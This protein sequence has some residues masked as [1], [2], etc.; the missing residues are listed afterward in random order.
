MDKQSKLIFERYSRRTILEQT[1]VNNIA[2]VSIGTPMRT[3]PQAGQQ[4]QS[5]IKQGASQAIIGLGRFFAEN[6]F[7]ALL[8]T[9]DLTP[10]TNIVQI[11]YLVDVYDKQPNIMN[12]T[13]L[14]LGG[15]SVLPYA[16]Q[17][18][19]WFARATK[20]ASNPTVRQLSQ[21][22]PFRDK[23]FNSN[24]VKQVINT[25]RQAVFNNQLMETIINTLPANTR[26]TFIKAR[27]QMVKELNSPEVL[28]VLNATNKE[29]QDA[30]YY[31]S[32]YG[33]ITKPNVFGGT[34]TKGSQLRN[35]KRLGKVPSGENMIKLEQLIRGLQNVQKVVINMDQLPTSIVNT[36][37]R[38]TSQIKEIID[39]LPTVPS[40]KMASS[41]LFTNIE[42]LTKVLL[43]TFNQTD[44]LKNLPDDQ[45]ISFLE[46]IKGPLSKIDET[47]VITIDKLKDII[48]N[49]GKQTDEFLLAMDELVS[50]LV[51]TYN[52]KLSKFDDEIA[53]FGKEKLSINI[54]RFSNYALPSSRALEDKSKKKTSLVGKV[55]LGVGKF[56]V[57]STIGFI[58]VFI[59]ALYVLG[60]LGEFVNYIKSFVPSSESE[61]YPNEPEE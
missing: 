50:N 22:I 43:K 9:L 44:N 60:K 14:V 45:L 6:E 27:E 56:A 11:P 33:Q 38:T 1:P 51:S 58:I 39:S 3:W 57:G 10:I 12:A 40:I 34:P 2:P 8:N 37:G 7:G 13:M 53:K 19:E 23:A 31:S 61:I 17:G 35:I 36:L 59:S 47:A 46:E 30:Y 55:A 5:D 32:K 28:Q 15:L 52:S 49:T 24:N 25:L 26:N 4:L 41:E 42:T 29:L 48:I 18:A 16:G 20:L 21:L 54:P